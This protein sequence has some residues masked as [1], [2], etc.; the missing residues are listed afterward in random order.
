MNDRTSTLWPFVPDS[1][2]QKGFL[3]LA[4]LFILWFFVFLIPDGCSGKT[5]DQPAVT[6]CQ[7]MPRIDKD[8]AGRIEEIPGI[9]RSRAQRIVRFR[10]DDGPIRSFD[11]LREVDGIGPETVKT[12]RR[13]ARLHPCDAD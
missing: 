10:R 1:S 5:P 7:S 11:Q 12:I 9:G 8:S 13:H 4:V 2:E 3:V 6:R